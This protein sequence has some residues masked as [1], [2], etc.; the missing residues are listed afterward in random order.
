MNKVEG[1]VEVGPYLF[2]VRDNE[3]G[4]AFL[5]AGVET[6]KKSALAVVVSTSI[7]SNDQTKISFF[8]NGEFLSYVVSEDCDDLDGIGAGDIFQYTL[9]GDEILRATKVAD[10]NKATKTAT[11]V[12]VDAGVVK[13]VA[14]KIEDKESKYIVVDGSD[15]S[16]AKGDAVGTV[17][18]YNTARSGKNA[19]TAYSSLS[20]LKKSGVTYT[21]N[22]IIRLED[23][24]I[25]DAIAYQTETAA[26]EESAAPSESAPAPCAYGTAGNTAP[27]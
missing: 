18:V 8:Q 10:Y 1:D 26:E 13:Y 2:D 22:V 11:K 17:A 4:V 6:N 7:V 12:A 15:Y 19:V 9:S 23:D 5:T 20:S 27:P 24:E 3:I 21:Y 16:F 25:V 14:G